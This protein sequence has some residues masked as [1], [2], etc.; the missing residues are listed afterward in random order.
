M[1]KIVVLGARGFVGSRILQH[2]SKRFHVIGLTRPDLDLLD[3]AQVQ[4]FLRKEQPDVVINAAATMANSDTVTDTRNNLGIFMNFYSNRG[5]FK[6]FVNLASGAEYDRTTNIDQ[7]E[8]RTI[9]ERMPADSYGF[10]QNIKSRICADTENF[11]NLRIFNCFGRGEIQTRIFP[12]LLDSTIKD[13]TIKDD[14]YFDFF[15]IK[16]LLTVVEHYVQSEDLVKDINCVYPT[17]HKIST[18]VEKFLCF[19]NITKSLSITSTSN[20]N[21]TGTGIKLESLNLPLYGLDKGLIEYD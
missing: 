18:V 19:Q 11:Y 13:F 5:L 20:L 6:K 2:L 7:A 1:K 17:K 21:Y 15:Y 8:E 12:K 16:D 9:F 4:T 10:G 3:F 14:R